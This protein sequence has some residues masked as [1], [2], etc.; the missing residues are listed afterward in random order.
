MATHSSTLARRIPWTKEPAGD[1]PQGHT[2]L[3]T[4]EATER[5]GTGSSLKPS[6]TVVWSLQDGDAGS[7]T[8]MLPQEPTPSS[9]AY[10]LFS[11]AG[12]ILN[13]HQ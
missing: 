6:L 11:I 5:A 7:C 3:D 10:I 4:T 13:G 9:K 2:E 12:D 1:R 8:E